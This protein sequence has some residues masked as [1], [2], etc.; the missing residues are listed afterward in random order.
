MGHD[1]REHTDSVKNGSNNDGDLFEDGVGGEEK[2]VLL[3]PALNELLV[4]VEL[5]EE[6]KIDDIDVDFVLQDLVLVLLVGNNA[7]LEGGAGVVGESDG[8]DETLVLLG[9][10]VLEADLEFDSLGKLAGLHLGSELSDCLG[11]L[12]VVDLCG[13]ST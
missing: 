1:L 7:D 6:V 5:L 2:G 9:V 13:H 4:L 10:V 8:T 12:L 3:G 11:N